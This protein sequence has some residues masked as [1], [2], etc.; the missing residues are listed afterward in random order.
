MVTDLDLLRSS[1]KAKQQILAQV[2]DWQ[3]T[4][5][6]FFEE[7]EEYANSYRLIETSARDRNTF[8]KTRA[9]ETLRSTEALT[10]SLYRM[11]TAQDPNYDLWSMSGEDDAKNLYA[12]HIQLR[13]QDSVLKWKRKLLRSL[14]GLTLFGTQFVERPWV[15]VRKFGA[16]EFE[17]LDF[18]PRSLLQSAFDPHVLNPNDSTWSAFIDYVSDDWLRDR[19]E[20]DSEHWDG[21]EIEKAIGLRSDSESSYSK[22]LSERR[23]K[24]GY[25]DGPKNEVVTFYGRLRDFPREDKRIW[26]VRILNAEH[27]ISGFGNPSPTG[28]LP[29][30]S[31]SYIEFENEPLGYGV[32]KLG[33]IAQKHLD[34]NRIRGI[35]AATW[36]TYMMLL[37]SRMSGIRNTDIKFKP[38]GIVEGED[39]SEAAIRPFGP[40]IRA[41][42]IAMKMEEG[43][44]SEFQG[45]TGATPNLQAQTTGASA[46]EA[47]LAQN[48]A[49]RRLSVVAEDIGETFIRDYQLEKHFHNL[50]WL[51]TDQYVALPGIEPVR[52]NRFNLA[53]K[54]FIAMKIVTDK[55]F[56][57]ERLKN[58]M[59][60]Y[61][62][63][64]SIRNRPN[65]LVDDSVILNE[66]VRALDF[67]PQRVI[68]DKDN[69]A[70]QTA[71]NYLMDAKNRVGNAAQEMGGDITGELDEAGVPSAPTQSTPIGDISVTP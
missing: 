20:E 39:I 47:G 3:T 44:R 49:L 34:F 66:I 14:R 67:D 28:S 54:V 24:A 65:I 23:Q 37:K 22:R 2:E 35:D 19:A 26:C 48:E 69:L 64:S 31:A 63:L 51:E 10:T 12:S 7:N 27:I 38:L 36:A 11:L 18:V 29:M 15:T 25:T 1:E 70:P 21:A 53:R 68:R 32:G 45:N 30:M 46:T 62:I 17:G 56:R 71:L 55:D 57:P 5:A 33:R 52:V 16:I 8:T 42:E 6:H 59:N 61:Q 58:L 9:G 40:D 41:I 60:L 43:F 13:Y 4:L 50:A